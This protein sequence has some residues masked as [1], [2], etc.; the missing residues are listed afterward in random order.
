MS[1][2][3]LVHVMLLLSR[4]SAKSN[5]TFNAYMLYIFPIFLVFFLRRPN[6]FKI[7]FVDYFIVT[8]SSMC[9][10]QDSSK[11]LFYL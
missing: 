5:D 3:G 8:L 10:S 6:Y 7:A 11:E 1:V 2:C 9:I 4:A